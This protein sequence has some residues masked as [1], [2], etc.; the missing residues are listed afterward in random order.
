M[1]NQNPNAEN[2]GGSVIASMAL[3]SV[4][5]RIAT[6]A[7]KTVGP[8]ALATG[9]MNGDGVLDLMV[10]TIDN[11]SAHL[12]AGVIFG[13]AGSLTTKLNGGNYAAETDQSVLLQVQAYRNSGTIGDINGDGFADLVVSGLQGPQQLSIYS[14]SATPDGQADQVL[15]MS[16]MGYLPEGAV[17]ADFNGDGRA[18]IFAGVDRS[19]SNN[20]SSTATSLIFGGWL[21]SQSGF[22][23]SPNITAYSGTAPAGS[24]QHIMALV[25]GAVDINGDGYDDIV[26]T[27]GGR[28]SP[29]NGSYGPAKITFGNAA[30]VFEQN[31][32]SNAGGLILSNFEVGAGDPAYRYIATGGDVNG[33]GQ[34]D[35]AG[36]NGS[37]IN[38]WKGT[39][40]FVLFGNTSFAAGGN[41]NIAALN[42]QNGVKLTNVASKVDAFALGDLNGDGLA[43]IVV[44]STAANSGAGKLW[45]VWGKQGGF[46]SGNIDLSVDNPA[47]F[48]SLT[49]AAG[50][51]I[52]SALTI[53][54]MNDDGKKDL[55]VGSASGTIDVVSGET[56]EGML[57][58][59]KPCYTTFED[60]PLTLSASMLLGNDIDP[61]GDALSIQ[62][63]QDAVGGSVGFDQNGNVVFT[64]TAN[65]NGPA[66]FTYTISDGNG[67]ADTATVNL[68]V[69]SD[70]IALASVGVRAAMDAGYIYRLA[71]GDFTGDGISDVLLNSYSL[72]NGVIAS[73]AGN[74]ATALSGG[75]FVAAP[76]NGSAAYKFSGYITGFG[77][78]NGDGLADVLQSEGDGSVNHYIAIRQGSS[79]PDNIADQVLN[80]NISARSGYAGGAMVA[81]ADFNGDGYADVIAGYYNDILVNGSAKAGTGSLAMWMGSANG[82]SATPTAYAYSGIDGVGGSSKTNQ[83]KVMGAID[84]NG[85]GFDDF[86]TSVGARNDGQ[87]AL[88][89]T[90]ITFGNA[91]GTLVQNLASNAGGLILDNFNF[92]GGD[93]IHHYMATGGDVNGD[94]MADMAGWAGND[95]GNSTGSFVLFGSTNLAAGGSV[96]VATLNGQNGVKLSGVSSGINSMALG[97]LNGDGIADIVVGSKAANANAGKLWVVWGKQGGFSSGNIDL[98]QEATGQFITIIGAAGQGIGSA[99]TIADIN[100]DGRKDLVIGSA[101]GTVDVVS[102]E[103]FPHADAMPVAQGETLD[104]TEDQVLEISAQSLLANDTDANGGTLSIASV[105][106]AVGGSVVLNADGSVTF[107]PDANY[108]GEASFDYAVSDGCGGTANATATINLAAVNDAPVVSMDGFTFVSA[109]QVSSQYQS[110]ISNFI[111]VLTD[112]HETAALPEQYRNGTGPITLDD[113]SREVIVHFHSEVAGNQSVIGFYV[114]NADGSFGPAQLVFPNASQTPPVLDPDDP[115]DPA[116]SYTSVSLGMLPAGSSFGLF[117]ISNG[118]GNSTTNA[119]IQQVAN[120]TAA[121]SFV[122]GGNSSQTASLFDSVPP[123]LMVHGLSDLPAT[124]TVISQSA[125]PIFHTAAS[126]TAHFNGQTINTLSLNTDGMQHVAAGQGEENDGANTPASD[127]IAIG[128]ED[129]PA[130]QNADFD[131]NDVILQVEVAE[132]TITQVNP[133]NIGAGA[134]LS[135]ADVDQGDLNGA[136]FRISGGYVAGD[137]LQLSGGFSIDGSGAVLSNGVATGISVVGGGFGGDPANPNGLSFT[138]LADL[139]LYEQLLRSI[140]FSSSSGMIGVR[141]CE[142][143]VLDDGGAASNVATEHVAVGASSSENA[144]AGT[145]AND[146]LTGTSGSDFLFGDTGS[147]TLAGAAG[148]DIL[149]GGAGND[150]YVIARGDGVDSISQTDIADAATSSDI[151]RFSTGVAF[152]QLW[153]RQAGNDLRVDV[154]GEAASSVYLKDWYT[155]ASRRID[156]IETVDGSHGLSAG[157]VQALVDAMA[158][159]SPPP[160]G[161]TVLDN[162]IAND[163]APVL[164]A[165]WS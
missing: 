112:T 94:G 45:V 135:L 111:N 109:E 44:S 117:M 38:E 75:S 93:P 126:A 86:V 68:T 2:N 82:L 80:P 140:T 113:Q 137:T 16:S 53:A 22:S 58:A 130:S 134:N 61:D 99:L 54:N 66:S 160:L 15:S 76:S 43:D 161:Q 84:I 127:R 56:F 52:G 28:T 90:K 50:Q 125:T 96:N 4:S 41:V 63:V 11:S 163:L 159:Y 40:G 88:G 165:A 124:G 91:A 10:F 136:V 98:S 23:T 89:P 139:A 12:G 62:S 132:A 142:I 150:I 24:Q 162:Q 102:G 131:F 8:S 65:Y 143:S 115:F 51:G 92:S 79:T 49:G 155:D 5:A 101:S 30:G 73:Q 37:Y 145:V 35:M 57:T 18:D 138:G 42:G 1:S 60:T 26:T 129:L 17:L 147:D 164:A 55:V 146:A 6:N 32:S 85:D 114:I 14:G 36:W 20:G 100:G 122:N 31:L 69:K 156:S 141:T 121:F 154:I 157:N 118:A 39:G 107:T 95:T 158:S 48:A 133:A 29:T 78:I 34:A 123:A 144:V 83:T 120:G 33:D 108:N 106:N 47:L 149:V 7:R 46:S 19:A 103:N 104:G 153:F 64:P 152:D 67:G 119:L 81:V 151:L 27:V 25:A 74:L 77:D 110:D 71:T 148:D 13:E 21:G 9:D 59:P 128:W 87:L 97:D 3:S 116:D 72:T 105:G 70:E